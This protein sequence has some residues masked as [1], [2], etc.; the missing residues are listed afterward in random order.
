MRG[1]SLAAARKD[2]AASGSEGGIK[3]PLALA[4][5][6]ETQEKEASLCL[7]R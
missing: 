4:N 3:S 2:Q 7:S 5:H 1:V 6:P